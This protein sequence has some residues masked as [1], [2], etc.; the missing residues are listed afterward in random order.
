MPQ[1][2]YTNHDTG[3][4]FERHFSMGQ[5]PGLIV[6]AD[7]NYTKDCAADWRSQKNTQ[8]ACWPMTCEASAIHPDDR[9]K[10]MEAAAAAG[11]PT[12]YTESGEPVLTSRSHRRKFLE[13]RGFHDRDAGYSDR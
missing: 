10:A 8:A 1:Y 5:A 2:T 7:G 12:D 9:K 3:D 6:T 4:S 13:F 11:V